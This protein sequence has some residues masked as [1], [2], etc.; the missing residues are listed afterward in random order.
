MSVLGD[1][2]DEGDGEQGKKLLIIA[3]CPMPNAQCPMPNAPMPNI[4]RK[5]CQEHKK[6]IIL[7]TNLLQLWQIS[8]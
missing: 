5:I 6:T 2:R 4:Q 7:L 1:W 3:Q 8:S